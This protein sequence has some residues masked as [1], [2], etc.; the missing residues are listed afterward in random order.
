MAY[1]AVQLCASTDSNHLFLPIFRILYSETSIT[2]S[3]A[4]PGLGDPSMYISLIEEL[5]Y[6]S[7]SKSGSPSVMEN[8]TSS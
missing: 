3:P 8:I 2:Y 5:G 7:L 6:I 4:F 1:L